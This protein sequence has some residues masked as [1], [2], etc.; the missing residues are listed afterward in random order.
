M[1]SVTTVAMYTIEYNH[2]AAP[3]EYRLSRFFG[4]V[5]TVAQFEPFAGGQAD[6]LPIGDSGPER[7]LNPRIGL[8]DCL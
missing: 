4:K 2:F 6:V 1:P 3:D 8:R 7:D 5:G